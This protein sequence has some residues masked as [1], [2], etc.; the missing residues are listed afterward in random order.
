MGFRDTAKRWP[1][2]VVLFM[3]LAKGFRARAL[4]QSMALLIPVQSSR[5]NE[6]SWNHGSG[7]GKLKCGACW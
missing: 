1:E 2:G 5:P 7:V 3:N 4:L 6:C